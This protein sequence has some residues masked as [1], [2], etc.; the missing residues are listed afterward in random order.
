MWDVHWR[1]GGSNGTLLQNNCAVGVA[2]SYPD[3]NCYAAFLMLHITSTASLYMENNWGW[4]ADHELDE[5]PNNQL[6]IFNGRGVLVESTN[7]VWLLGSS[8]EHSQ[9]YNYG[10]HKAQNVYMSHIQSEAA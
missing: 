6:N 9:L 7:P 5:V 3:P 1:I 4:V 2:G 10:V 8:F